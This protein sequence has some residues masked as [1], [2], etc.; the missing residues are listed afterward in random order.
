GPQLGDLEAVVPLGRVVPDDALPVDGHAPVVQGDLVAVPL[1]GE[2]GLPVAGVVPVPSPRVELVGL[3]HRSTSW[4]A[5]SARTRAWHG[6]PSGHQQPS[7][8]PRSFGSSRATSCGRSSSQVR[9]FSTTA[10]ASPCLPTRY[11]LASTWPWSRHPPWNIG[12]PTYTTSANSGSPWRPWRSTTVVV[13]AAGG[14]SPIGDCSA[15]AGPAAV[16]GSGS[17]STGNRSICHPPFISR[18]S[19][20]GVTTPPPAARR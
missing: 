18:G 15:G 7:R 13:A 20:R 12:R 19:R 9:Y 10:A 11:G 8:R 17:V 3:A 6:C 14:W 16:A 4:S 5:S 2:P 1:D